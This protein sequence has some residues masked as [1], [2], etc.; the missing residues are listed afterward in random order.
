MSAA[1]PTRLTLIDQSIK[2]PGGHHYEYALRVLDAARQ[3]GIE[4]FLLAHK[5]YRGQMEHPVEPAFTWTFWDNYSFYYLGHPP[6]R[7]PGWL[8]SVRR[9]AKDARLTLDRRFVY[10]RIGLAIARARTLRLRDILLRSRI[11]DDAS[12][13]TTSRPLLAAARIAL[14]LH[15]FL[16]RRLRLGRLRPLLLAPLALPALPFLLLAMLTG[17][18]SPGDRFAGELSR[19]LAEQRDHEHTLFFVPNATAAELE[20][21]ALLHR[22]GHS[23]ARGHWAFLYRRPI[24]SGYPDGY[25]QQAEA[26][27]RYRVE[28]A[29]LRDAAPGLDV[30]FYTDTDELTAQY[31]FLGVFPFATLPVPVDTTPVPAPAA[32][33]LVIGYLGDA[34]DE[35]GCP[36]LPKL[37]DA[38]APRRGGAPAVR[39]LFQANYNIP[40]GEPRS[41]YARTLLQARGP[42]LVE[43]AHG[44]FDS[45]QYAALL[46]RMDIVVI[47]YA[48]DAY[49][50]RSSGIL[51]EALAAGR[52]VLAPTCTWMARLLEP[53]RHR[54]LA[55]L[56]A[57]DAA[58][59]RRLSH[60]AADFQDL[61]NKTL[62]IDARANIVFLRLRFDRPFDGWVRLR[63]TSLNEF[64]LSLETTS[65]ACKPVNGE[66]LAAFAKPRST[67]L[68]WSAE[69][70]EPTVHD[71]PCTVEMSLCDSPE[72][73]PLGAGAALFDAPEQIPAAARELVAFHD[74]HRRAAACLRDELLPLCDPALLVGELLSSTPPIP[75]EQPVPQRVIA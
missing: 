35:K 73:V 57:A 24:F 55:G 16:T 62:P 9:R 61:N 71:R 51:M 53:S 66:I 48:A 36:Y 33:P 11:D 69:P 18:K 59:M 68:R 22:K 26:A 63:L 10:S 60:V 44:P 28:L 13:V 41:R 64:D 14:R 2:H 52:P 54:H 39:F 47:P 65:T 58:P 37:V 50:A 75:V 49:S 40:G 72:P 43:L 70:I 38:F 8:A 46:R 3:Q 29:R 23:A 6:L 19:A 32:H 42:D 21:L 27:R 15:S 34:R 17:R 56:L 45:R 7:P 5:D 31:D 74:H 4:T 1:K 20:G 12:T 67:H 25:R 30:R